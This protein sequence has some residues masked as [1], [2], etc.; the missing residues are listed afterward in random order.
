MTIGYRF[1]DDYINGIIALSLNKSEERK[2]IPISPFSGRSQDEMRKSILNS[3][4]NFDEGSRIETVDLKAEEFLSN[5]IGT[6][7]FEN[8]MPIDKESPF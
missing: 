6:E 2:L 1:S 4:E 8:Y 5:H 7:F 3:L